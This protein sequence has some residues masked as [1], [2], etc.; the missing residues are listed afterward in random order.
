ML[1]LCFT[2]VYNSTIANYLNKLTDLRVHVMP[3]QPSISDFRRACL[4]FHGPYSIFI[5]ILIN[6]SLVFVVDIVLK[7]VFILPLTYIWSFIEVLMFHNRLWS[8]L[9][10]CGFVCSFSSTTKL[11]LLSSNMSYG[12]AEFRPVPRDFGSLI[13]TCSSNIQKITQNSESSIA[14]G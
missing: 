8:F 13:Q 9:S 14:P 10:L 4:Y 2:F 3:N 12:K 11:S 1:T 5:M 7:R 6:V